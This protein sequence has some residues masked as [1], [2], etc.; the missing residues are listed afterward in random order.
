MRGLS[1]G[2]LRP[3]ALGLGLIGAA[4]ELQE[5]LV[6]AMGA[7]GIL[8]HYLLEEFRDLLMPGVAR[9]PDVLAVVVARLEGMVLNGYEVE[10]DVVEA[11]FACGH[12]CLLIGNCWRPA[13]HRLSRAALSLAFWIE[14]TSSSLFIVERSGMSRRR[15]TS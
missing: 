8:R 12:V 2:S 11:C 15:A 6:A 4:A 14:S 13:A 10:S 1:R 7:A 3:P 5:K 9:V